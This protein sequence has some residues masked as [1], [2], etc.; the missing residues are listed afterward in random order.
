MDRKI[1]TA[2]EWFYRLLSQSNRNFKI[3]CLLKFASSY[4]M[5]SKLNLFKTITTN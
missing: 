2:K 1:T 4:K 3:A 5:T